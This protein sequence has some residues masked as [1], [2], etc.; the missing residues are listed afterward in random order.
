MNKVT[1]SPSAL[2]K[3]RPASVGIL[4]RLCAPR[5]QALYRP[6]IEMLTN[7]E[8]GLEACLHSKITGESFSKKR[9]LT[10]NSHSSVALY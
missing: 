3:R 2:P 10:R 9:P 4:P 8:G 1:R 7:E 5:L 6:C